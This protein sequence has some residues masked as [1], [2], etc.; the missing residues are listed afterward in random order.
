MSAVYEAIIE[1][2]A[3]HAEESGEPDHEVGDLQQALQLAIEMMPHEVLKAYVA[4]LRTLE[5]T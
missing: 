5:D 4:A 2:A 1:A 3:A